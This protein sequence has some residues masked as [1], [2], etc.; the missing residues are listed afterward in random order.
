MAAWLLLRTMT[1][2]GDGPASRKSLQKPESELLTMVLDRAI[3]AIYRAAFV[4][5][6]TI[7]TQKLSRGDLAIFIASQAAIGM[8][9]TALAGEVHELLIGH[10]ESAGHLCHHSGSPGKSDVTRV[11]RPAE[12]SAR[13]IHDDAG[14]TLGNTEGIAQASQG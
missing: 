2:Q 8:T 14:L 6:R 5:L 12:T 3:P 11:G 10:R 7:A 1:H 9:G 13:G 4:Q